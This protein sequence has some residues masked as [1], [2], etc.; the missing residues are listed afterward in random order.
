[1][2]AA[3]LPQRDVPE[4]RRVLLGGDTLKDLGLAVRL[5][6]N[7]VRAFFY[8][9]KPEVTP[10]VRFRGRV[11]VACEGQDEQQEGRKKSGHAQIQP[12]LGIEQGTPPKSSTR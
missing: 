11:R 7:L 9:F 1:M 2:P 10:T 5:Y 3:G 8:A 12:Q 4:I 6:L